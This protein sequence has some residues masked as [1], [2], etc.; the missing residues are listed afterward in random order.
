MTRFWLSYFHYNFSFLN[1]GWVWRVGWN[2][3]DLRF[4]KSSWNSGVFLMFSK[5]CSKFEFR[6]LCRWEILEMVSKLASL[7]R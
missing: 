2:S 4:G 1:K 3:A 6:S 7:I 5:I